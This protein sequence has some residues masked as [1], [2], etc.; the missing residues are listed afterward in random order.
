MTIGSSIDEMFSEAIRLRDN[1]F[2]NESKTILFSII[3]SYPDHSKIAMVYAV[4]GGILRDQRDYRESIKVFKKASKI[5][6]SIELVSLGIY[7]SYVDMEQYD[8]A[9]DEL[10]RFLSEYPAALY[11]TTLKELIGDLRNGYARDHESTIVRLS[12]K[13]GIS[14]FEE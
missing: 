8:Y 11:K 5:S 10:D 6:P 3:E 4:L 14:I 1:E 9:I 2:I 13:H 7:L 12:K